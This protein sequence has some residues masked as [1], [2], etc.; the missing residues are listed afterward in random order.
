ML[1]E[2]EVTT[3][4]NQVEFTVN[5]VTNTCVESLEALSSQNVSLAGLSFDA[6][7]LNVG[8]YNSCVYEYLEECEMPIGVDN[9]STNPSPIL[10]PV[11]S[12][13]AN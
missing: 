11:G 6:T 10:Y 5:N 4:L 2:A 13:F 8:V 7:L 3:S 12:K 1:S 9:C